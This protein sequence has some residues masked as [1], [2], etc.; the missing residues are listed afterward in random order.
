MGIPLV[1]LM[2]RQPQILDYGQQQ[3]QA[4]QIQGMKN[5]NALAPGNLQ[6][7]QQQIE[8]QDLALKQQ[9]Q[10][11]QDQQTVQAMLAQNNGD[12][13]KTL[14]QLA[15]KVSLP[16]YQALQKFHLE[17]IKTLAEIDEKE[18][19]TQKYEADRL[20][21][22]G[23]QTTKLSDEDYLNN[24]PKIAAQ[25]DQIKPGLGLDPNNPMPRQQFA[26]SL[27]GLKTN[28]QYLDQEKARR[29]AQKQALE[30]RKQNLEEQ[31][32]KEK[33]PGGGLYAPTETK[34]AVAATGGNQA[35]EAA[36]KRLDQ[37]KRE[38][39]PVNV[40]TLGS[41]DVKDIAD[42]IENGDQP[43]TLQG[44][45]RNAGPVRAELA[46]RGVPVAKMEMDWK[47]TQRY[48]STLN[49]PQQVRL[50]QAITTASDSLDKIEELYAEWQ[51]LAPASGFKILNKA[52]LTASMNLPG[53]TGAVA[54]ALNAQ[55]ADLTSELGN[56]Y[57]GGN[58]PTDHALSLAQKNL[59]ADWNNETFQEG[60][61][62][63]RSNIK[64]RQNSITHAQPAGVGSEYF[65]GGQQA[66]ATSYTPPAG[67]KSAI[68]PNGHKIN[69]DNGKWVDSVTG[70]PI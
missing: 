12:F 50:R 2:G 58:S 46:R 70:A 19:S 64:I 65:R 51:K 52:A 35:A 24:W 32:F 62:Q 6:L 45:Y 41:N 34:L 63:A 49:G 55:I 14:P 60:L 57:M 36:L 5:Q 16:T 56:V 23:D 54:T 30:E 38:S 1:A 27:L 61:K 4:Q 13:E 29:E 20:S 67:A 44:L 59:S 25:A 7:Q 33:L 39:R 43:P 26:M 18:L 68:G 3:A 42:A 11:M 22:L 40:T 53:R 66:P 17:H 8:G 10:Q 28:A 69:V 31:E 48:V 9:K 37:S 15:G 21:A 47:A